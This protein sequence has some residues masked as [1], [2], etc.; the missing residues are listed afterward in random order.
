[1]VSY[2]E[3]TPEIKKGLHCLAIP[4]RDLSTKKRKPNIEYDQKAS[5]SC[6]NFN[7]SNVGYHVTMLVLWSVLPHLR[8][9]VYS[10][11]IQLRLVSHCCMRGTND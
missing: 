11:P 8:A 10:T 6:S 5:E 9:G 7:I 3:T 1:M 4:R 2:P